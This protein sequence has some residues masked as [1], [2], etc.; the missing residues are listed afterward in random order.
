MPTPRTHRLCRRPRRWL[1]VALIMLAALGPVAQARAQ[2]LQLQLESEE[3]YANLPF[4][5]L[6]GA[7]GFDENPTPTLSKL[8]IPGCRVTAL[9]MTPQVSSMVQIVNGQR[10]E[11]RSV[12]FAFRFRIE[13]AQAGAHTVPALTATQGDRKASSQPARF[14]VKDVDETRDMQLRLVLPNRPLWVGETVDGYLD[15]YLRRDVG[16]RSFSVPLFDQDEWLEI[17]APPSGPTQAKLPAFH[18]GSRALELPFEQQKAALDGVEYSR[19]RFHFRLT[20]S[21]PGVLL[22]PAARVVAELQT[23]YGR[24]LFGFQVPQSQ[25]FSSVAKPVKVEI[26][27]LP[28]SGRPASFKNAVGQAFAIDVQAGRTVVRVGDPIELRVLLRGNGRLAGLILPDVAAMGLS[29]S[30]FAAPEE[31]PSGELLDDG[32]GKLFRVAVRLRSLEAK[33]IPALSFGYFDPEKG[34]YQTVQSQP[35]ALSVKGSAVVSAGDVVTTPS[36]ATSGTTAQAP[37]EVGRA[38]VVDTALPT[39]LVGADLALSDE[40]LTLLPAPSLRRVAPILAVLYALA[41]GLAVAYVLIRGRSKSWPADAAIAEAQARLRA[42]L[43]AA[44][45]AAARDSAPLLSASLRALRSQLALPAS[46]GQR[47]IERLE[48]EAY[49]PGAADQP[50]PL[51]L[52][53]DIEALLQEWSRAQRRP[54][55]GRGHGALGLWLPL[56]CSALSVLSA[57]G[58]SVADEAAALSALKPARSAYQAALSE[59]DRDR[60]RS[61]FAQAEALL[62]D[63][64]LR[65]ADCPQLLADW[66]T[67]ALLAQEPGRA[68]LAYRRALSLD[69][70]LSRAQRNLRFLRERL[71]DWLPRPKVSDAVSSLLFF[72]SALPV[73]HR[74]VLLASLV[75]L[76]AILVCVPSMVTLLRRAGRRLGTGRL[77]ATPQEARALPDSHEAPVRDRAG[78]WQR[79]ALIP[80]LLGV[81]VGLSIVGEIDAAQEGVVILPGAILR[82]ADSNGAPPA[83]AHPLPAGTELHID[84]VRGLHARVRLADGQNGWIVGSAIASLASARGD[85]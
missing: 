9:G 22:P 36:A 14:V 63:L 82:S 16:N 8:A 64:S 56:L 40:R 68:V 52:R 60:R 77:F 25:L 24:D 3:V 55:S 69:P 79:L 13:A 19:F 71:P 31:P 2:Q 78:L 85:L 80:A 27:G 6:V 23:G 29:P 34:T 76:I 45:S 62:R 43:Q 30:L 59:S 12:T 11:Q 58:V 10:S 49:A 51:S 65:H 39:S 73:A 61:G 84:E 18:A 46:E 75:L 28:Q 70:S 72:Q 32:K 44:K 81:A 42:D 38:A 83:F 57:R 5:L 74:H 54:S 33:E 50:L 20:P 17:E 37:T 41:A 26:R 21:K 66:G 35:I 48:T 67:A 7:R 15:W 47:L 1:L 53:T 4:V